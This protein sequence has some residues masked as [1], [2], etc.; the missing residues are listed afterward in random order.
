MLFCCLL[1]APSQVNGFE[2][3]LINYANERLQLFFIQ[4]SLRREQ[5]EYAAEGIGYA[6]L[7]IE[8]NTHVCRLLDSPLSSGS[9]GLFA[10]LDQRA[11]VG[12]MQRGGSRMT[13]VKKKG[14]A[15][16]N[17]A[18]EEARALLAI[19]DDKL[20]SK[21]F[22]R[23]QQE[24]QTGDATDEGGKQASPQG[25]GRRKS[26]RGSVSVFA[27]A[28]GSDGSDDEDEEVNAYDENDPAHESQGSGGRSEGRAKSGGLRDP[29]STWG[30][31][32]NAK[33]RRF[34][35]IE[36]PPDHTYDETKMRFVPLQV[37]RSHHP[38]QRA[39]QWAMSHCSR[40]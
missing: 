3:L 9:P 17:E 36:T 5:E 32:F 39:S 29:Q 16:D 15:I 14:D 12:N 31:V 8:D 20:Q 11:F 24:A 22:H 34:E 7:H 27:S 25:G 28:D 2:Q 21:V 38:P 35:H 19:L 30:I 40:V 4:H 26:V 10:L 33:E 6:P 37:K 13:L 18:M 1:F 23:K